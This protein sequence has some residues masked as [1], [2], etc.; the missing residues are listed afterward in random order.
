MTT[1]NAQAITTLAG[2]V[3][4]VPAP[5]R[6]D[7]IDEPSFSAFCGWQLDHGVSGLVVNGTT[8]EAPNLG[9]QEQT[10]LIRLA[11][12]VAGSAPVIAGAGSNSTAHAIEI[13][14][15]AEAAGATALL[16]VTPY[17]VKPSQEGLFLHFR[18][19]HDATEL[20]I[21]LY[22]VPSR[23]GCSLGI[24]TIRRL[25]ELPR[26]RGLKDATGDL[27]RPASLR[28]RLGSDFRLFSGDDATAFDFM[29][30]GGDGCIS[31]VS[32]IVP[33]LCCAV[34]LALKRGSVA[35][36]RVRARALAPLATALFLEGNPVPVKY[37]LRLMG[38]MSDEVR[39]PLCP[40]AP[41]TR[42]TIAA[43]LAEYGLTPERA[44]R[45]WLGTPWPSFAGFDAEPTVAPG[46]R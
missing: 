7:R 37:A 43:L 6:G 3:T 9:L 32:N 31:V 14:R 42:A 24:D 36:A 10:R 25:A 22:D 45:R 35:E 38:R 21:L 39:L 16:A 34:H 5:F 12:E 30:L 1:D 2:Y 20:P 44:A 19:L 27:E 4:A 26:I 28:R 13:A 17:Y 15:A 40:P 29:R 46:L 33:K 23:T 8:G 11:R 18:A 41:K